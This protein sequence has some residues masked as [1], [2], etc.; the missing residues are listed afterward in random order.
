MKSS[1]MILE[2][3]MKILMTSNLEQRFTFR[4]FS[5]KDCSTLIF[6]LFFWVES[7]SFKKTENSQ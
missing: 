7:L 1:L 2:M 4:L 5:S 6:R 3:M